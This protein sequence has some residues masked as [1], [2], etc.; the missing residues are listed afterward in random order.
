MQ[1]GVYWGWHRV[2]N[3]LPNYQ[4]LERLKCMAQNDDVDLENHLLESYQ[5]IMLFICITDEI[6]MQSLELLVMRILTKSKR[7]IGGWQ[8]NCILTATLKTQMPIKDLLIW[9]LLMKSSQIRKSEKCM[10]VVERN[11]S[12]KM[13][14]LFPTTKSVKNYII[15]NK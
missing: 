14:I 9:E 3:A 10:I 11:A 2:T 13:V 6:S 1:Q 5:H 8:R 12:R 15:K 4:S 7:H